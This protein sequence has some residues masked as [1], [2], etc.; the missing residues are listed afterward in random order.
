MKYFNTHDVPFMFDPDVHKIFMLIGDEWV[1][2]IDGDIKNKV[3]FK[4]TEI[5]KREAMTLVRRNCS[6][7]VL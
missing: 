6:P 4:S 2:I 5:T 7:Q 3:R 1:E